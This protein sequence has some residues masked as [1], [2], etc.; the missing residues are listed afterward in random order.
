MKKV[1]LSVHGVGSGIA[2]MTLV[3]LE[4]NYNFTFSDHSHMDIKPD[5]HTM[6]VLYRLGI[7][8][9]INEQ[10]ATNAARWLSPSYPGLIDGP[11]WS[12]G[13]KWCHTSNPNCSA[14][15]INS[16]CPKEGL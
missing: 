2:S 1:L 5:V 10:E 12:I 3:L 11:L 4:S 7:S 15:P 6:R 13:R 8:A 14:C 9:A 16:Y